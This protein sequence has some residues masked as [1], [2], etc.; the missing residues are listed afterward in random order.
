M[1][2]HNAYFWLRKDLSVDERATFEA[3]LRL[4]AKSSF[5]ENDYTGSTAP[6][7]E[8]EVTDHSFDFATS[9]HFKDLSDH[10]AYQK[11]CPSHMRF[12]STCKS[13]FEKVI[14]YDLEPLKK[15]SS[16]GH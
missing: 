13:Y 6:T 15:D 10:E 8:R 14:V 3:E 4:L 9:F 7:P 5:I 1:L 2:I 11:D 12:I 16:K